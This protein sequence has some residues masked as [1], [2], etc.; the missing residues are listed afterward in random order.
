MPLFFKRCAILSLG[1]LYYVS[2]LSSNVSV[3]RFYADPRQPAQSFDAKYLQHPA[4]DDHS[5][6]KLTPGGIQV[7]HHH[8]EANQ[9]HPH[10]HFIC[11]FSEF[12]MDHSL[13]IADHSPSSDSQTL[14]TSPFPTSLTSIYFSIF[15]PPKTA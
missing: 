1:L 13:A 11:W 9:D 8:N 10:Q 3:T 6:L 5:F 7:H 15:R 14:E 4:T 2:T 12:I